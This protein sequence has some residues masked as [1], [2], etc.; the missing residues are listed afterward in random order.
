M[1]TC[2]KCGTEYEMAFLDNLHTEADCLIVQLEKMKAERDEAIR[3]AVVNAANAELQLA[4]EQAR[5]A[6]LEEALQRIAELPPWTD[7]E[8]REVCDP[9]WVTEA[10]KALAASQ[11]PRKDG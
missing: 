7:S 1:T 5:V 8:G 6:E 10:K 11:A 4:A 2:P 3:E 9:L